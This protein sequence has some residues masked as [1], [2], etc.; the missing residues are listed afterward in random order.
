M[1][2]LG[3]G[4]VVKGG[5]SSKKQEI[6]NSGLLVVLG[7]VGDVRGNVVY[8]FGIEAA[9]AIASTMMMGEPVAH[10]DDI[11]KS[12]L[13]ELT[14]M[15]TAHAATELSKTGI[16]IGISTPTLLYGENMCVNMNSDRILCVRLLADNI[17]VD[18]NIS[19]EK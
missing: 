14:N 5:I 8:T 17:A 2:Q 13:S 10:L 11:A 15:L 4:T 19:F 9:K 18:V 12:A 16:V 6:V 1:P 7:V 3:F